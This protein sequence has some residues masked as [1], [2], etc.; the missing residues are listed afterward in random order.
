MKRLSSV[1]NSVIGNRYVPRG[2]RCDS[3]DVYRRVWQVGGIVFKV[4]VA[5]GGSF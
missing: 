2:N 1:I 3:P 5:V 4:G